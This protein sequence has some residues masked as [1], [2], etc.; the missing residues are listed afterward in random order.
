MLTL[1]N[2][3]LA[4]V[5]HRVDRVLGFFSSRPNWDLPHPQASVSPP[6]IPKGGGHSRL[7]ERVWVGPNSDEGTTS[8]GSLGTY[9]TLCGAP[10]PRP[11]V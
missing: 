10:V 1:L 8:V 3:F 11:L 6:L 9:G 2:S 7:R 5:P 4:M